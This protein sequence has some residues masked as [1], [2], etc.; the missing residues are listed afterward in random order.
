MNLKNASVSLTICAWS[1]LAY[2]ANAQQISAKCS[3]LLNL[4]IENT[5]ISEA[6]PIS[7]GKPFSVPSL[8]AAPVVVTSL[9]EHCL[10]HGEVNHHKSA[11]GKE[12]GDKFEI[13]MP[14]SWQG[15]LLFS[16][17]G[18]LDGILNPAIGFQG[19]AVSPESKSALGMGYAVVTTDGGHQAA[20]NPIDA[21]FGS[22]PESRADYNSLSTRRVMDVA[23]KVI[24]Q[25]YAKPIHHSYFQG[26]SNGG[27]EGLMA[28]QRYP[29]YFDG[30]VAG[31]PAFNL[32]HAAIAEAW[33]T[34][35]LASIAPKGPNGM[36]Q[37]QKGLTETDLK[38]LV[39][40]VLD[41]CDAL[42]GVKDG[43]IFNPEAC[44]FDPAVLACKNG[45]DTGCLADNKVAV[46]RSI[47]DGPHD[48]TGTPIY[49]RW[50]YDSGQAS[51]GWRLWM[52]GSDRMASLNV[53]IFP[54]FFNGL[55]LAGVPPK[56]DIFTFDFE[57]DPARIE[58]ASREINA[59]STDWSGFRKRQGKL[60]LYTGMS[61][62]VFSAID[63][64]RYYKQ[65][66]QA[67]GGE[68]DAQG[69]ARLFLVPG[70]PHCNGAP[71]LD[72][73]DTLDAIRAWVE[74]GKAPESITAS[75][76]AFPGRTRP[77]CTYPQVAMYNG[78][79]NPENATSFTCRK[80]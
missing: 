28:G 13:R 66:E 41:K 39:S 11:D 78:S 2:S 45:Q 64:I 33:N 44:H 54:P 62:P 29:E 18:G 56:I 52:T 19:A 12:Y 17:G 23:R 46:I 57:H 51:D 3:D 5:T 24:E 77:L 32:T 16:G 25:F 9:P 38:L 73:F 7:A 53:L 68:T 59:D 79:G 63:L 27:R 71:G 34:V 74:D 60:L 4:K 31:A 47:F 58:K 43:M 40:A 72:D 55:A 22:D 75:G 76:Q 42:D 1:T 8:F 30:I 50:P 67:N 26:C 36:P 35:Q 6:S 20:G 10:V 69:F 49:S 48:S 37:L 21:S 14:V 80:P 15:R 65:V 70:M 61:D